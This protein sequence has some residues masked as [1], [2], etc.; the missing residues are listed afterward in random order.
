MYTVMFFEIGSNQVNIHR[1]LSYDGTMHLWGSLSASSVERKYLY[2]G[3]MLESKVVY[4]P[5]LE[6]V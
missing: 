6:M 5:S 2:R 3:V 4:T 1:N